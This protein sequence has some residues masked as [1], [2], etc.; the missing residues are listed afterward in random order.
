MAEHRMD[1]G[2]QLP[3]TKAKLLFKGVLISLP[4]SYKKLNGTHLHSLA[5]KYSG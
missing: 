4:S 2:V 5:L 3:C 1:I